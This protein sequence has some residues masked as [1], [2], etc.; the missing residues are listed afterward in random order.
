MVPTLASS[1][2]RH[3]VMWFTSLANPRQPGPQVYPVS[4]AGLAAHT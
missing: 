1:P 4:R 2:S 3:T